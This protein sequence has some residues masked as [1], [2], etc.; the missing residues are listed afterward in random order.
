M[1]NLPEL[2][3]AGHWPKA[4]VLILACFLVLLFGLFPQAVRADIRVGPKGDYSDLSRAVFKARAGEVLR[5]APGTYYVNDLTIDKPLTLVGEGVVVLRSR[6]AVAK[7]LLVVAPNISLNVD[8]LIFDG[9]R[10]PDLNGA[11]IRHEGAV[12]NVQRSVFRNNDDGILATGNDGSEISISE[13]RF[14]DNG[15]GDG[16]SHAIY[17]SVG[18]RLMIANSVFEGTKIG[19]HVKSLAQITYIAQTRFVDGEGAPSYMVDASKGGIL[20]IE[21]SDFYRARSASQE[22]FFNYDTTRGG[23]RG[24]VVLRANRFFNQKPRARLVRNPERVPVEYVD[25]EIINEAGASLEVPD[26]ASPVTRHDVDEALGPS[27]I[28]DIS[29]YGTSSPQ[30][31]APAQ[32]GSPHIYSEEELQALTPRQR[33]AVQRMQQQ[34]KRAPESGQIKDRPHKKS[35]QEPDQKDQPQARLIEDPSLTWVANGP[36]LLLLAAYAPSIGDGKGD[37][38]PPPRFASRQTPD[39]IVAVNLVPF[40][41]GGPQTGIITFGQVFRQCAFFPAR[42]HLRLRLGQDFFPVQVDGKAYYTN[43]SLKHGLLSV[44]IPKQYFGRLQRAMLVRGEGAGEAAPSLSI[45]Q[46]W[47]QEWTMD[48]AV[49]GHDG[50]G[51]KFSARLSLDRLA[52]EQEQVWLDGPLV[53][54]GSFEAQITPLLR[55]LIDRRLL[56]DGV[57][58]TT[59]SFANQ[60]AFTD[61]ARDLTYDVTIRGGETVIGAVRGVNHYR[62]SQWHKIFWQGGV[63]AFD[64]MADPSYLRSSFAVPPLDLAFG[65][66]RETVAQLIDRNQRVER[67][68]L[69]PGLIETYMPAT[70]GRDDIG[71]V[72]N[73]AA[74]WL[75]SGSPGLKQVILDQ[76]DAAG[77]IP[78]HFVGPADHLPIRVDRYADFWAD[79]R[80]A[81]AGSLPKIFFASSD[82]GWQLDLAHKP[83]LAMLA[84]V[85]TGE[86]IYRRELRFEAAWVLSGAWPDARHQNGDEKGLLITTLE[87]PRARAWGLRDLSDAAFILPDDDPMKAYFQKALRQNLD[88]LVAR[89]VEGGAMDAAGPLEGWFAEP[90]R[91]PPGRISP[92][93]ND[94]MAMAIGLAALRGD[95]QA[96]E[97]MAWLAPWQVG[98]FLADGADPRLGPVYAMMA[99]DPETGTPLDDWASVMAATAATPGLSE[100]YMNDGTGYLASAYGALAMVYLTTGSEQAIEAMRVLNKIFADSTL[101]D[102]SAL[103]GVYDQATMI[104]GLI[105]LDGAWAS[106]AQVEE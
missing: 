16:Y 65:A 52:R 76:A 78:W 8:N 55:L 94:Y 6:R 53:R 34:Q 4:F 73:W 17:V 48:V 87:Q 15:R 88:Y 59:I 42:Q 56:A 57:Q 58:R 90:S 68:P 89:N 12:L 98:R 100:T 93:Q 85:L 84:Y 43:G 13:T 39:D 31:S 92:W 80:G 75:K 105:T 10:S 70:G 2:R 21:N 102:Q 47:P 104:M 19:H 99:K 25:N 62:A 97:L 22:N 61:K 83:S 86:Q 14:I 29:G 96:G 74:L 3:Q 72:P 9:A 11:G 63:P 69:S 81:G 44:H 49:D 33:R 28:A 106:I 37:I 41:A 67:R 91:L 32:A 50:A 51:E 66:R 38:L 30:A 24:R 82:G 46:K 20:T 77:S 1:G 71:M 7:G 36:P 5:L 103:G 26:K 79:E 60:E 40:S 27:S 54:E 95:T 101:F 35:D 64:V 18:R 45:S 23:E